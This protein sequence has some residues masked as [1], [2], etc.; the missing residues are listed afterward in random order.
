MV[1]IARRGD[2]LDGGS[3]GAAEHVPVAVD[4]RVMERKIVL[5]FTAILTAAAPPGIYPHPSTL[6]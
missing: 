3:A 4:G 6:R 2:W 1:V 5:T